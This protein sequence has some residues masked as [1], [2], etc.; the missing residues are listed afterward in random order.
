MSV[1][2]HFWCHRANLEAPALINIGHAQNEICIFGN[3]QDNVYNFTGMI[4]FQHQGDTADGV[5]Y[6]SH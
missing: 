1:C 4:V 5:G 2:L 3:M 6:K